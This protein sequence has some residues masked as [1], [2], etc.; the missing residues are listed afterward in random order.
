MKRPVVRGCTLLCAVLTILML[1]AGPAQAGQNPV[2]AHGGRKPEPLVLRSAY[3]APPLSVASIQFV[4]PGPPGVIGTVCPPIWTVAFTENH[5]VALPVPAGLAAV[6]CSDET[7]NLKLGPCRKPLMQSRCDGSTV[8]SMAWAE[9]LESA[10]QKARTACSAALA[11][12]ADRVPDTGGGASG[13]GGDALPEPAML[14]LNSPALMTSLAGGAETST[15]TP[16][17]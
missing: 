7:V 17:S 4:L 12:A 16:K 10:V 3:Q 14:W 1:V 9:L 5:T 15:G 8:C 13:G 6:I 2:G 11:C